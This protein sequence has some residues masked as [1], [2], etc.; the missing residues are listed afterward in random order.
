MRDVHTQAFGDTERVPALVDA[1]RA[2]SPSLAPVSLVA[3]I[4]D[5]VVGHV[6][7]SAC[8]L[9]ALP[10]LVDVFSLSPL[11]VLP[12]SAPFGRILEYRSVG[13]LGLRHGLAEDVQNLPNARYRLVAATLT[14]SERS[15]T[16]GTVGDYLVPYASATGRRRGGQEMFPGAD[17]LHVPRAGH[18]DLLNHDDVYAAIREWLRDRSD[19]PTQ[20]HSAASSA[21]GMNR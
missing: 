14:R 5:R 10:R 17:V 1:L 4:G 12:E 16:S 3:T 6:M 7:L 11:G 2:A 13:I 15:L 19:R 18:F 20:E 9:D 8:R 21:G